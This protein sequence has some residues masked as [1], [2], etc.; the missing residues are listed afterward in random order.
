MN[1]KIRMKKG[2]LIIAD[3]DTITGVW[4]DDGRP[5]EE[6]C[7]TEKHPEALNLLRRLHSSNVGRSHVIN[8]GGIES[9]SWVEISTQ[10]NI[11][12]KR[13]ERD[14]IVEAEKPRNYFLVCSQAEIAKIKRIPDSKRR[15]WWPDLSIQPAWAIEK[16]K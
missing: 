13:A 7:Q 15:G 8:A 4:L 9:S 10:G 1:E 6:V 16:G 14:I 11:S 12:L 3:P 5:L 2:Q